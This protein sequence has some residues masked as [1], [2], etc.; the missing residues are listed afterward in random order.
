M[1]GIA[2]QPQIEALRLEYV[3]ELFDCAAQQLG[4]RGADPHAFELA[5]ED[6]DLLLAAAALVTWL[7]GRC[8]RFAVEVRAIDQMTAASWRDEPS[9]PDDASVFE[10]PLTPPPAPQAPKKLASLDCRSMECVRE[11]LQEAQDILRYGRSQTARAAAGLAERLYK[12]C[13]G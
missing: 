10:L 2:M 13:G 7:A 11:R 1:T 5:E 12:W 3:A 8:R 9:V 4:R 6:V